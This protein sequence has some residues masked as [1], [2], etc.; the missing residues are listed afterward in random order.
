MRTVRTG[1][2]IAMLAS[3]LAAAGDKPPALPKI[4]G[5]EAVASVNGAPITLDEYLAELAGLHAGVEEHGAV[6]PRRDPAALLARL[7]DLRLLLDE[8]AHI[9]LDELPS[10]Q[11]ALE[12]SR[13]DVLRAAVLD[14]AVRDL[15]APDP[16]EVERRYREKVLEI[17]VASVIF[18]SAP[19]AEAF[20]AALAQGAPDGFLEAG[21]GAVAAGRAEKVEEPSFLKVAEMLPGVAQTIEPL[22][23]GEVAPVVPAGERFAVIRLLGRRVPDVPATREEVQAEIAAAARGAALR[24]WV[25]RLRQR[26]VKEDA[27]VLADLDFDAEAGDFERFLRDDR[28]VARIRGAEPIRVRDLAAALKQ[29]F[30]HGVEQAGERGRLAQARDGALERLATEAA[31]QQEGRELGLDRS[32][33]F[34][35]R[36]AETRGQLLF[37]LFLEKVVEPSLRMTDE[38]IRAAYARNVAQYTTPEMI[39]VESLAFATG[40]SGRQALERLQAGADLG[41]MRTHADERVDAESLPAELRFDGRLAVRDSLPAE[42]RQALE[43]AGAGAFRLFVEPSGRSH[44]LAVRHLEP[45]RP[46]PL[47]EVHQ[48]VA[49]RLLDEKRNQAVAEWATKLRQVSEVKLFVTSEQLRELALQRAGA[50]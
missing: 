6:V 10:F 37:G 2:T 27:A 30:F 36:L 49:R 5:R 48:D 44:V 45:P 9:G 17:E 19:E 23:P 26:R 7:I 47:E 43:G 34:V 40:A 24:T 14:R 31:I 12:S 46:A 50:R 35:A 13:R 38:E 11:S 4:G 15:P 29:R 32:P 1:L 25:E 28:P 21:R 33:E 18:R 16:A 22:Q 41:W 8:A 39:R 3:T 20:R 42:V